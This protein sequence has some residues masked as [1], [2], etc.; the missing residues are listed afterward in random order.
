MQSKQS[1]GERTFFI[2]VSFALLIVRNPYKDSP[3]FGKWLAV[4][5]SRGRGWWIPGGAVDLGETFAKAAHRE[6]IEEAGIKVELKGVLKVDHSVSSSNSCRMRVIYYAEPVSIEE[7]H[8]FKTVPDDE[9]VEARWVTLKE[10]VKLGEQ[11]PYLRGDELL[12]WGHYLEEGGAIYPMGVFGDEGSI[13]KSDQ[14]KSF[15]II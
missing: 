4:N 13:Q 7:A 15:T 11:K 14:S 2:T 8:K 12:E 10:L 9:S 6:C 3:H 5:E 1:T